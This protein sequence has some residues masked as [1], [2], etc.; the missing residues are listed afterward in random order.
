MRMRR[1]L[2][3]TLTFCAVLFLLLA[4]FSP[5]PTQANRSTSTAAALESPT[6][7]SSPT[8]MQIAQATAPVSLGTNLAGIA[9]WS[10]QQPFLD[11]FKSGRGWLTQCAG[12]EPGCSGSW[13][14]E[15]SDKLD[16]DASGWV[17]SLPAP[18]DPPEYTRVATLLQRDLG[19]PYPGGKYIVL[20]DGEGTIEYRFD[21]QKDDAA[22]RPG[23]DVINVT[24]SDAGIYMI[25]TAT[26]PRQQGNYIRNIRV[27]QERY[28]STFSQEVFNPV[29]LDRIRQFKTLRFMDW[30]RTNGS[31]QS[32]WANRPQVTDAFYSSDKG[33]PLEVMIDLANRL[34]A[35]A[36]FNMPHKATDEY[37]SNFAKMV[38]T[39]L[40]PN[41]KAYVELSNEVWNWQFP[42]A[43]YALEQGR[44]R[45]N[46]EGD[47]FMQWYGMRTAQMATIWKQVFGAQRD[48]L[49]TVM[50]TQTAWRGLE[51]PALNCPL[52]V[53]EGNRP[54]YQNEVDA[55]A[56]AGYFGNSFGSGQNQ[57]TVESWLKDSDG[58]FAKAFTQLEQGS[59][60]PHDGYDDS[61]Q[62]IADSFRYY[63]QVTQAKGLQMIAYEGGQHLVNAEN[64]PLTNFFLA[65]N[66]RP[67]MKALY[68]QLL[69]SW[70][71]AG[72][73]LFMNFS[74]IGR[75]GKWGSW[76][77]LEDVAQERSPKYDALVEFIERNS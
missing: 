57:A 4:C 42:Q 7:L 24:P 20:Y 29:F 43:H 37:M 61:L 9:D 15:E 12:D 6:P 33:A 55:L 19:V 73:S 30:M 67:E 74:D 17:K 18:A 35:D 45:W 26:D 49:I 69:D 72:G 51:D 1:S 62:G 68:S 54:C 66:R 10:T 71:Q 53:K 63:K 25:I 14:T 70:K 34:N 31:N 58:G 41:L 2:S 36:W 44:S 5:T 59:L 22:S 8:S 23:R 56:I 27:V 3:F 64:E 28:E 75:P 47:A 13:V 48:R 65:I 76:G 11:V 38:Q 16:L 39:R 40:K 32:S 50:G 52:W 21:A 77:V 60:I 46:Q